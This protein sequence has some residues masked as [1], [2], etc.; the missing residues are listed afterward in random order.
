MVQHIST[1]PQ[2]SAYKN[3]IP[4]D[5]YAKLCGI[6]EISVRFQS[7]T[8]F[9]VLSHMLEGSTQ[10]STCDSDGLDIKTEGVKMVTLL[11]LEGDALP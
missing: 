10:E 4:V 7:R 1:V 8:K 5:R 6:P 2:A 3:S 11:P 9:K